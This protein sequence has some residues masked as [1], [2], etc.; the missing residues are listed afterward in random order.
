M[1]ASNSVGTAGRNQEA[2]ERT[3][4]FIN[5]TLQQCSIRLTLP[6]L[7]HTQHFN[8]VPY[9]LHFPLSDTHNTSTVFHMAYTSHSQTHT[10]LQQ[11]S[12]W[13]TV[14][15]LRH[16]QHFN[17]VPYG[18]QFPLSDTHNTSTV[19]HMSYTSHSQTHT[20]L[21]QCSIW[22]TLPTFRHTQHFNSVPYGLH[23]PLS[24][25]RNTSTVF[26]MSYTS[27][28]QTHA[29]L[30]QCSIWLT[31]PTL[32]HTQHFNSVPYGLHFQLSDTHNTSTVFHMAYT[33]HS[34][35]H[36]TLQ[37][38]SIW[39][40]LPTLRHTQ[41]FNSVPYGLHFPLSDTHNTSTVF[42]MAYTSHSQTHATLQQCSIWLTVPTLRHTQHFNSVPYGLQFPLSDTRNTS[43][44]FHMAYSSHSQ[45]HATLQQ[46]S[47]W[48]TVP[49][50]RHTQHFNSVPH[51]LHF[52]LSD[53]RN[54]STVF[55]MAYTSHSQTHATLQQC[56]TWL[57]LPTLRHTQHFNSVPYGLHFPL[58]DTRN[59][60]TVFHRGYT[61]HSQT[62]TT[63]QQCSIWLTLPT[64]RQTQH[65][66]SVPY[67]LQFPL[68]DTRN[69]S[70]VFHMAYTSNSQTNTT[71][72][73]CSIWLTLPTLRHTQHFNSI[74]YG[75]HFPLSDTRSTQ[76]GVCLNL[77]ILIIKGI[78]LITMANYKKA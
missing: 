69:T 59:T 10:T 45:T 68:S 64:L 28:S 75:L 34:Q 61:S 19:F 18:L 33:S 63:L 9:G 43:T 42:H 73:Q 39:L 4:F 38:C 41:H 40:T 7:R 26:H 56:S 23:F 77:C 17:S 14:P 46:C 12:I 76:T 72:Q 21:Q 15:P 36:T 31:L 65:F 2:D 70:T 67:G 6:I 48:L 44:V 32:R 20:P 49:T 24:D 13:L 8:S 47:I 78:N 60:S 5:T 22:L 53:T 3:R 62:H 16:T 74:P 1:Q 29:T 30:Q 51:G 35:T 50:L 57:T 58:S 37:Q 52:P 27:H 55:H 25:T 54:T 66:N 71:L 11:C